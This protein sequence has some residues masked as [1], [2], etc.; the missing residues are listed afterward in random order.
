MAQP[1][2]G[3]ARGIPSTFWVHGPCCLNAN[4][5]ATGPTSLCRPRHLL[6]GCRRRP[7][8]CRPI[9]TRPVG[10]YFRRRSRRRYRSRI[11]THRPPVPTPFP[12]A[13][14]LCRSL[15]GTGPLPRMDGG[16]ELVAFPVHP[17]RGGRHQ[18][19]RGRGSGTR[20][21]IFLPSPQLGPTPSFATVQCI[22]PRN[23]PHLA[24]R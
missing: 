23:A 4:R 7:A 19:P 14:A 18:C 21:P 6:A 17:G 5:R 12:D 16:P 22:G 3:R 8:C 2:L 11:R 20:R 1:N 15:R 13:R 10:L 24:K 9:C